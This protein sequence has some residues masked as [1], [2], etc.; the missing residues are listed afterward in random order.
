MILGTFL[1]RV[2]AFYFRSQSLSHLLVEYIRA[3]LV[4]GS[5]HQA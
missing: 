1:E 3:V 4:I 5:D 2:E